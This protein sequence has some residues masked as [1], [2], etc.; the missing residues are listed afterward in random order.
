MAP[1]IPAG[2]RRAEDGGREI[3]IEIEIKIEIKIT[4]G[5]RSGVVERLSMR[6][7]RDG[8]PSQGAEAWRNVRGG[9]LPLL[10]SRVFNSPPWP[11]CG[12]L[13]AFQAEE[14]NAMN[15]GGVVWWI[16]QYG[17][18]KRSWDAGSSLFASHPPPPE[19]APATHTRGEEY[20]KLITYYHLLSFS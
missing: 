20:R 1:F 13:M 18:S 12:V 11:P 16:D 7:R 10:E 6:G 9:T 17:R 3:T 5:S 4:S 19:A 14:R 8:P 15:S 2:V